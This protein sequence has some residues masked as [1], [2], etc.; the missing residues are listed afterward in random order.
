MT[1]IHASQS[2]AANLVDPSVLA[3]IGNLEMRAKVVVEGFIQ[4]LHRAPNLGASTDFAEH[5]PYMPG[6]DVRRMDWRLYARTD[7]YYVKE[8]EAD[9][10][11]NLLVMLD[12]S[13]SMQFGNKM[14]YASTL[15]ACLAYFSS[16][17][18][19]R[20]GLATF[21]DGIV[22]Y[23]PPSAKH[24]RLVLHSLDQA[25]RR[26]ADPSPA[27]GM[28]VTKGYRATFHR[29]A[30]TVRR[31]SMVAIISDLYEE[32]DDIVAAVNELRGRGNDMMV[33][34]VLEPSELEFPF[35]E[36]A[37]FE[38][39]ETGA[40]MPVVPDYLR[41][42]YRALVAQHV[43]TLSKRLGGQGVDYALFDTSQ[44]MDKALFRYLGAR[45]KFERARKVG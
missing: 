11:T 9:T 38:D 44:P 32:P 19:D 43:A 29:L 1:S 20:V 33:L 18:R 27:L 25:E 6:D 41:D 35:D 8:F 13:K 34:H 23:V 40:R 2:E 39:V 36:S 15:A 24:L 28:T 21:A 22:D 37:N 17:Q 12:V 4:G 7:R 30:D 16:L 26:T 10:N 31:R 3:R 14:R 5:R 45:R 42:E